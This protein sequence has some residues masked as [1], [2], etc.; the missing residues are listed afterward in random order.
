MG[1]QLIKKHLI[2]LE[3]C[4]LNTLHGYL[5]DRTF[6]VGSGAVM[7]GAAQMQGCGVTP[8]YW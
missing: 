5:G 4:Q 2:H 8:S 3:P 7:D 6:P 1:R